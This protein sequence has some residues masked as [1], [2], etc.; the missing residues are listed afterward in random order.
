MSVSVLRFGR[1]LGHVMSPITKSVVAT[2]TL[3]SFLSGS[4]SRPTEHERVELWREVNQWPPVWQPETDGIKNLHW[5]VYLMEEMPWIH[6]SLQSLWAFYVFKAI[7]YLS[8]T[9]ALLLSDIVHRSNCDLSYLMLFLSVL[10]SFMIY[11][12]LSHSLTII[13]H[14][15]Q[16]VEPNVLSGHKK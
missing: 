14:I 12:S 11:L 5:C 4:F 9:S 15:D 1:S 3:I 2:V 7:T 13:F 16:H 10:L 6:L 8:V